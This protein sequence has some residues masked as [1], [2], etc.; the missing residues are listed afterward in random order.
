LDVP[1]D[2]PP[3]E[4]PLEYLL[5]PLL[6]G[7]RRALRLRMRRH[8]FK[9]TAVALA[10][11]A[12]AA[13]SA[14]AAITYLGQPAPLS[15]KQA[16]RANNAAQAAFQDVASPVPLVDVKTATT[17]AVSGDAVLYG[18]HGV[19][20][21]YCTVLLRHGRPARVPSVQC[22]F[23]VFPKEMRVHY[24]QV[25][26]VQ[27]ASAPLVFSGRLSVAGRT[28]TVRYANGLSDRVPVGLRGYFVYEPATAL[29]RAAKRGAIRLIERNRRGTITDTQLLQPPIILSRSSQSP[30]VVKG[31]LFVRGARYVGVTLVMKGRL[32]VH[33]SRYV[34]VSLDTVAGNVFSYPQGPV[35]LIP[36]ARDG[37][38]TWRAPKWAQKDFDVDLTV[39]DAR[40]GA[41]VEPGP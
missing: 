21:N 1:P 19:S 27:Q 24:K 39:L 38:F 29:Q 30:A 36:V 26:P 25:V 35:Q 3:L 8:R 4:K 28:L 2:L 17:V 9:V 7:R 12:A 11:A 34:G 33:G 16:F 23:G 32:V 22:E 41:L 14:V 5:A 15:V 13:G 10:A 37:R 20:G 40:F 6:V 31:R 18:A